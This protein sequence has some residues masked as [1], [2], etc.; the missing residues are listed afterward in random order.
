MDAG[1][2]ILSLC[3]G[4]ELILCTDGAYTL[5]HTDASSES[6]DTSTLFLIQC[7]SNGCVNKVA[8][9]SLIALRYEYKYSHGIF[10]LSNLMVSRIVSA[11]DSICVKYLRNGT[12]RT[13]SIDVQRLRLHS[14]LGLKGIDIIGTSFDK[15][16]GW[17]VNGDLINGYSENKK[18]TNTDNQVMFGNLESVAPNGFA[19]ASND[20]N[21]YDLEDRFSAYLKNGKNIPIGQEQAKKVLAQCLTKEKFWQVIKTLFKCN[22]PIYRSPIIDYLNERKLPIQRPPQLQRVTCT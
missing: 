15:V 19:I 21:I 3:Q 18:P 5:K 11:T 4:T 10:P 7:Y 2:I 8:I 22:I 13:A 16:I 6:T 20:E 14:I 17:Y 12:E 1:Y 9:D